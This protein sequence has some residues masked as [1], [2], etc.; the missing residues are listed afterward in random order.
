MQE[1]LQPSPKEKDVASINLS[2]VEMRTDR[3]NEVKFELAE[4]RAQIEQLN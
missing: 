4:A 1:K 3:S 2:G